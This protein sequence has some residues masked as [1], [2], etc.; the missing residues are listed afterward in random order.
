MHLI[1]AAAPGLIS[2][3]RI[4]AAATLGAAALLILAALFLSPCPEAP[5]ALLRGGRS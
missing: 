4:A 1:L 3:D 2:G 5:D